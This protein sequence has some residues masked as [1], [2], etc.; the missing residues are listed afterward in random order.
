MSVIEVNRIS[1]NFGRIKAADNLSFKVEGGDIY[2]LIGADG[3]GKTTLFRILATLLLPDSGSAF[4]L[5]HDVVKE[6]GEIR[7]KIGYMP[8][9]FSLYQDMSVE[10][11]LRFYATI[12]GTEVKKNYDLIKDIYIHL[13]PFAK[14][15]AGNLSGG[16]KQKL[17]LCCALIH[18][19]GILFLDEPTTGID[20]VSRKELWR[21]LQKLSGEGITV[22]VSTP[23][24]DEA[25]NCNKIAFMQEGKFLKED[26]PEKIIR[27]FSGELYGIES[28]DNKK[29]L[30][31]L[32]TMFP[33]CGIYSFGD[34]IHLTIG[35][36]TEKYPEPYGF[37]G[38]L[39]TLLE[40]T[41]NIN[42][43]IKKIEPGLEDCFMQL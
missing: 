14:R 42:I 1:K 39:K 32:R 4:V 6:Y 23:Y 25:L 27:G 37:A 26:S 7:R 12:F 15:A 13:E 33:D 36:G 34:M 5:G 24:M 2:G 30:R 35:A 16:M 38:E 11:N 18:K 19:P 40:K 31:D 29:T 10:E 9:R 21:M 17:A 22:V 43:I 41:G 20:P 3:A 28:G 8:G